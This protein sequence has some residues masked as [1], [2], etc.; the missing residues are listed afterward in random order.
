MAFMADFTNND[1]F[2][3]ESVLKQKRQFWMM[4][5]IGLYTKLP[6]YKSGKG[7]IESNY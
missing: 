1:A 2:I 6:D 7:V 4:I 5:P 3:S